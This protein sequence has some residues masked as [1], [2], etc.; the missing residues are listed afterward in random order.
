[1]NKI[2]KEYET[3]LEIAKAFIL[4]NGVK[5]DEESATKEAEKSVLIYI[6]GKEY[7]RKLVDIALEYGENPVQMCKKELMNVSCIASSFV[8]EILSE[9]V[10]KGV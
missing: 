9:K 3:H 6:A 4:A 7:L 5:N 2:P 8:G 10:E 1:M